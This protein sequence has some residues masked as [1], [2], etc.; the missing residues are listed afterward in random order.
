MVKFLL[1][2]IDISLSSNNC[3]FICFSLSFSLFYFARSSNVRVS[4][5]SVSTFRLYSLKKAVLSTLICSIAGIYSFF[6][7]DFFCSFCT[8]ISINS[9]S[10]NCVYPL[11]SSKRLISLF[12][13]SKGYFCC[14]S[15]ACYYN[16]CC[17]LANMLIPA[18]YYWEHMHM[19]DE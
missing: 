5:C 16:Y 6:F 15:I 11:N 18:E 12:C 10:T 4:R 9:S 13:D 17:Y 2:S 3:L 1:K 7:Y 19:G 8:D 14:N